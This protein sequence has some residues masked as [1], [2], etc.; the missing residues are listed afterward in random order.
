MRHFLAIPTI[1]LFITGLVGLSGAAA[2]LT[3][4]TVEN[5]ASVPVPLAGLTGDAVKGPIVFAKAKCADCHAIPGEAEGSAIGPDLNAVG[6]RL[7]PGEIRLMLIDPRITYPDTDMP[8]YYAV[9]I[10]GEAPD[11]LVGRTRLTA[12]EIE[13]LVVWLSALTQARDDGDAGGD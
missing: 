11:E 2:D 5:A 8:A 10:Y 7:T 6:T 1:A 4:Y 13:A 12:E 9:G 3:P